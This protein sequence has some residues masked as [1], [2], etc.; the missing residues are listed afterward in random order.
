[1]RTVAVLAAAGVAAVLLQS[2]V[3]GSLLHLPRVPNLVLVLVVYLGSREQSLG[4][5]A[6]AF[7]L[8]CFLD[9]FAGTVPGMNAF[10]LTAAYLAVYMFARLLWMRGAVPV[11][12]VTFVGGVVYAAAALALDA[13]VA[14]QPPAWEHVI[15]SGLVEAALAALFA[16][17]VFRMMG[18][19]PR[20]LGAV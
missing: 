10:A 11:M 16:P 8:G 17:L 9:A 18:R 14:D 19:Q 1:M 12:V 13:I 3:L 15:R 5:V 2:T 6:G 7:L 20:L 4:G